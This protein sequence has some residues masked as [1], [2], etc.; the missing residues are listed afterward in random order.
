MLR[1]WYDNFMTIDSDI[2]V[3]ELTEEELQECLKANF[4]VKIRSVKN[5]F[6]FTQNSKYSGKIDDRT[7]KIV[8]GRSN[9]GVFF[10]FTRIVGSYKKEDTNTL[11]ELKAQ[12]TDTFYYGFLPSLL[13]WIGSSIMINWIIILYGLLFVIFINTYGEI[14]IMKDYDKFKSEFKFYTNSSSV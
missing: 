14:Q 4:G 13:I 6:S 10:F 3:S 9:G 12:Y 8:Q 1:E 2:V 7:F 11:I 5:M